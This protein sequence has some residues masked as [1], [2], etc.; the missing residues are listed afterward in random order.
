MTDYTASGAASPRRHEGA[1]KSRAGSQDPQ[2]LRVGADSPD[3]LLA[4]I[5]HMLGF[6]PSRSVLVLGLDAQHN[7][8][9]VTFRYDLPRRSLRSCL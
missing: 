5:P 4:M 1:S 6:Y 2:E 8:V 9:R 7:R 3:A